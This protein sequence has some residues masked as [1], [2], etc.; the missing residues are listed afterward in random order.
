MGMILKPFAWLLMFFYEFFNS[1]GIALILFAIVVKTI[2][3]PVTLKSKKSMIQTTMLSGRMEQL[4][5]QYGRDQARYNLELQKLYEQEHVNPMGGCLWSLI[6]MVVLI[7]LY[8]IIREPLTYMMGVGSKEML[9]QI[10]EITGVANSGAFPQI[11]MASALQNADL[12]AKAQAALGDA[13]SGLFALDFSF[14]GMNLSEIPNWKFW[15]NGISWDSV[16]LFLLPLVST[17]TSFL[18]MK[19]SFATNK[20]NRQTQNTQADQMNKTMM[21]TMPL[22][23]LWI[24]YT[25]PAG[26]CVYWITQYIVTMAQEVICAKLLKKDYEAAQKAAEERERQAKEDEKKRKEEARLE[27]ARR[28]EEEKAN[29]KKK[30]QKKPEEPAGE[31]VNRDDSR[32]G[33]RA[34]ARGRSYIPGRFGEVT[35]YADPDVLIRRE[36]EEAAAKKNKK[37]DQKA[38]PAEHKSEETSAQ[39]QEKKEG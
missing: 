37:N 34:Y 15:A 3:F 28:I 32:E 33:I 5:K 27:R 31:S 10:S 36:M 29:K 39:D 18:S 19:V 7:G 16:G 21:W 6:P 2:L 1:Y 25:L 17:A 24:G 20:I 11:A 26:L 30:G 9:A 13:G 12:M 23:S 22:L 4:K 14:L 35:P 8:Y 38:A